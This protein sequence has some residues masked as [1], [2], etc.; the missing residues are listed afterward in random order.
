MSALGVVSSIYHADGVVGD[1]GGGSLELTDIK[2]GQI[3]A[4]GHASARRPVADG[5]FG[6]FA[7]KAAKIVRDTLAGQGAAGAGGANV[8]C[9]RRH[10]AGFGPPAYAPAAISDERDAQLRHPD[11]RRARIRAS[12][13]TDR[14]RRAASIEVGVAARRPLLAYG[15]AVLEEIIRQAN[16]KE[17]VISA[18]GVR[19]GLIYSRLSPEDQ[20]EDPLIVSAERI[21]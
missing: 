14:S 11:P 1:L 12:G 9:G 20:A 2:D 10:L 5:P 21:Q 18:L 15:A 6:A 8:L 16:P 19:E 7:K 3:G 17:I 13:R 4:G